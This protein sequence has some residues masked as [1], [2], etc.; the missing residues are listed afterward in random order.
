MTMKSMPGSQ[1]DIRNHPTDLKISI[2]S[3]LYADKF[4]FS[5]VKRKYDRTR[6][7]RK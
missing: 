7:N 4:K 3:S 5:S 1:H 6:K 2:I